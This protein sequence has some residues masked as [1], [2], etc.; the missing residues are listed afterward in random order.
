MIARQVTFPFVQNVGEE[1][2]LQRMNHLYFR[3]S[4]PETLQTVTSA[5]LFLKV[6]NPQEI[7]S[8]R[9]RVRKKPPYYCHHDVR[10]SE[11]PNAISKERP[12]F[13]AA[14]L[15]L[16]FDPEGSSE[17]REDSRHKRAVLSAACQILPHLRN[18]HQTHTKGEKEMT[19]LEVD[20]ENQNE[21][22]GKQSLAQNL[23]VA[24]NH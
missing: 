23:P 18:R 6:R 10:R 5:C 9:T 12:E 7:H 16:I 4:N 14:N 20:Y 13:L 8:G 2:P 1:R 21:G 19:L 17:S 22:L 24:L 3:I 15:I 11:G